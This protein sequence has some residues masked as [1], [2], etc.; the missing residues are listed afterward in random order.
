MKPIGLKKKL[1]KLGL[2]EKRELIDPD[3]KLS[4]QRQCELLEMSRS[5][6]YYQPT[7]KI[8]DP[9]LIKEM[10][11]IHEA[12]PFFGYRRVWR[13]LKE[14]GFE[15]GKKLVRT[16]KKQLGLKTLYPQS[17]TSIPN[18]AHPKYPYLLRDVEITHAN[19]V[20]SADISYIPLG[21][22]HVYLV[23]IIDWYS[24]KI[25]SYRISNT[26]DRHFCLEALDEALRKYGKPEI[27]N[28]DQGS[29]FTSADFT[30]RLKAENI[31]I[32]MDGKGRC[33]DNIFIERW[34][35]S[36]KYEDIYLRDYQHMLELKV[37]VKRYVKFYNESRYHQSLNYQ[38]PD[39]VYHADRSLNEVKVA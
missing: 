15:V 12:A 19:H 33:L 31:A 2:C 4:I 17:Q 27:F 35:R 3:N 13:D 34:F 6:Y 28:T 18:K 38:T 10:L 23:G 14:K 16:L 30:G 1:D 9:E 11:E 5:S 21:R 25:L 26:M 32:S 24:R 8:F 20:W 29:Q 7:E 22:S 39:Q 37:G 36:L